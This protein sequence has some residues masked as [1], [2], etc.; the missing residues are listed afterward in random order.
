MN[1]RGA[2][3]G[4]AISRELCRLMKGDLVLEW[5]EP[6]RGSLFRMRLPAGGPAPAA[7]TPVEVELPAPGSEQDTVLVIDDDPAV[8]ELL[9]R[10]LRQ[11]GISV[12]AAA[13]GQE[14]L[15]LARALRPRAI[16][17]DVLMP[18][19]D[20]W[21]VLARLK[22]DP[23]T[24][25]IPVIMLSVLGD[26]QTGKALG[27]VESLTKPFS[28]E[29]LLELLR[30]SRRKRGPGLVLVVDDDPGVRQL[31]Q[32]TLEADGCSVVE[33]ANGLEAQ[34]CLKRELPSLIILDLLMPEMDGFA[35]LSQLQQRAGWDE[36][37]ILVITGTDPTSVDALPGAGGLVGGCIK[38]VLR[39]GTFDGAQLRREARAAVGRP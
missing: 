24:A 31:I 32:Q 36:I 21:G 23:A 35:L 1:Y 39:K 10:L 2:G 8:R 30:C 9:L 12:T 19:L 5:S 14:G 11:E 28:P 6:G 15:E 37:P 34:Q 26:D 20:G 22:A 25:D 3:L 4:L 27:V 16:T 13:G 33:A 7:L 38:R 29:R 17:L 18:D